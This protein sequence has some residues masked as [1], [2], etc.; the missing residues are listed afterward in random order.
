M[1]SFKNKP[2]KLKYL[3]NV[4]TLDEIHKEHMSKFANKK[5]LLPQKKDTLNKKI[6][7]LNS[8]ENMTI[9]IT[10]EIIHKKSLLKTE[11][12]LLKDEIKS[13]EQ[14]D[15]IK[16][17]F[18]KTGD[19]LLDYYQLTSGILYNTNDETPK[20]DNTNNINQNKTETLNLLNKLSQTKRKIKKPVKK[21]KFVEITNKNKTILNFLPITKTNN[22][23]LN[24]ENEIV[25]RATLQDN[26]LIL[27]DGNY[28]SEHIKKNNIKWC[29]PCNLEKVIVST[30]GCFVC[31]NCGEIENTVYETEVPSHS[32]II[33]E[34]QKYPYKKLNHLKEKLNQFQAKETIDIPQNVFD[35]IEKEL[36]KKRINNCDIKPSLIRKILRKYKFTEY[37]EHL[38]QIYCKISGNSPI[39]ISK[40]IEEDIYI[41]FNK[42]QESYVKHIPN[43]RSNFLNYS[44]VLN[45]I[46]K[47]LGMFQH[48]KYFSLLKSKDKLREQD[49]IWFK[50]CKDMNWKY[51][52]STTKSNF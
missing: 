42:M 50:I 20:Q 15:D 4:K 10:N 37:Y 11:I 48:A 30:E 21:R 45:K 34:K 26:Y 52:A 25:N 14:D 13:I 36:K 46:F 44:Y 3:T 29:N 12:Q 33:N 47:I 38:Q 32:D 7:E 41:M 27:I 22:I 35:I 5:V 49:A 19:I 6:V 16:E 2:N 23:K 28:T 43:N 31:P 1:S 18:S 40:D 8:Y 51:Y 9:Q 39:I 24:N 17:Y